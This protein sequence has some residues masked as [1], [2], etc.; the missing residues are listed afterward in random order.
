MS[1]VDCLSACWEGKLLLL[2]GEREGGRSSLRRREDSFYAIA[3]MSGWGAEWVLGGR[4]DV[5]RVV[6]RMLV[7][8]NKEE[9][10]RNRG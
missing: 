8:R 5:A 6:V 7:K 10:N 4:F 2:W 3:C 9:E 1:D